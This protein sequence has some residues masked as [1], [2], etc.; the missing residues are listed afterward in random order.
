MSLDLFKFTSNPGSPTTLLGG[1]AI[2]GYL[3]AMWVER[4]QDAGEFEIRAT[5]SSGL[6]EFLPLDTFISRPCTFEVMM[7][8][9]HEVIDDNDLDPIL[10]I[11][12]RSMFSILDRRVAGIYQVRNGANIQ[13]AP[14]YLYSNYRSLQT[15]YM[16]NEHINFSN[17]VNDRF[18][19]IVATSSIT[20]ESVANTKNVP[21]SSLLEAVKSVC[22]IDDQGFRTLRR[23]PFNVYGAPDITHFNIY[24]GVDKSASVIFSYQRGDITRAHYLWTNKNYK[25]TMVIS[26]GKY[27]T[28]AEIATKTKMD[29][30]MGFMS[31][32]DLEG[33]YPDPID[34]TTLS[35]LNGDMQQLGYERMASQKQLNMAQADI[36]PNTN[37]YYRRDYNMGD[38]VMYDGN[39]GAIQKMRVIEHVEI[40]DENGN[41]S[42]PTLVLPPS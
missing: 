27:V 34:V 32:G 17:D 21:L 1:E 7:V 16:I 13:P 36:S 2:V 31:S 24:K 10:V 25:T 12:G 26:G 33:R 38:L 5:L 30:R 9:N 39:F 14:Y 3:S 18:D 42:H 11:T 19:N 6:K 35:W 8:E 20:G 4:Y 29:R 28:I 15:V 23:S 41:S 40:E 22:A 37:Y